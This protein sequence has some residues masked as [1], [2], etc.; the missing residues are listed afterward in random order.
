MVGKYLCSTTQET[1]ALDYTSPDA[2]LPMIELIFG[3]VSVD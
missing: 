1:K 3:F 2:C